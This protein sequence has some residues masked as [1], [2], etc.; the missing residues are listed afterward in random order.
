MAQFVTAPDDQWRDH[1][2]GKRNKNKRQGEW[3]EKKSEVCGRHIGKTW[4]ERNK[5]DPLARNDK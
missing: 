4:P 5:R 1:H 2:C 3:M